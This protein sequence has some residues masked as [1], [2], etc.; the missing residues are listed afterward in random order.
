LRYLFVIGA[1]AL[2]S[3]EESEEF[4]LSENLTYAQK[5]VVGDESDLM[6]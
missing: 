1:T 2:D 3:G 5:V 4:Y 6:D